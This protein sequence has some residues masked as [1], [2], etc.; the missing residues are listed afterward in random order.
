MVGM[1]VLSGWATATL[2]E[3]TS[4]PAPAPAEPTAKPADAA[5]SVAYE[6][7]ANDELEQAQQQLSLG[8]PSDP[9]IQEGLVWVAVRRAERLGTEHERQRACGEKCRDEA[10]KTLQA[11]DHAVHDAREVIA[12]AR[13][14][15]EDVVT[16]AR[17]RM[18]DQ[19]I[20]T[21]LVFAFV[22][23]GELDR[24]KGVLSARLASH[25]QREVI[26]ETLRARTTASA[27]VAPAPVP[28]WKPLPEGSPYVYQ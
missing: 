24:A 11:L 15:T 18:L 9:R 21:V 19:R 4:R 28:V 1:L 3:R 12:K 2:W 5:L 7:L 13:R 20:H 16:L 17:I 25:P 23:A 8:D 6:H 26:A 14:S 10:E 27:A 22:A